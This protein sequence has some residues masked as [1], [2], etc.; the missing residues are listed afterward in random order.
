M[1]FVERGYAIQQA[2]TRTPTD[3]LQARGT[4]YWANPNFDNATRRDV[5][6]ISALPVADA[7]QQFLTL[8]ISHHQGG[9]TMA[10]AVLRHTT[11]RDVRRIA[12]SM[13]VGRQSEIQ[14][15]TAMLRTRMNF[16]A[17]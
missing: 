6:S 10:K 2:A 8:M 9:V 16:V 4:A 17:K 11:R 1:A 7:E 3:T 13:V 15:M 14:A 5:Q 12:D